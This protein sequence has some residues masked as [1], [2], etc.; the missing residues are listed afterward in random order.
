MTGNATFPPA[1]PTLSGDTLSINRFLKDPLW[2]MRVLRTI[3]EQMFV[4]DKILTG[5]LWT[6]S[7]SIG[8]EQTENIYADNAPQAVSPGAPYPRTT[9]GRGPASMANTVKWAQESTITDEDISRLNYDAIKR[10]FTKLA[11]SHVKAVDSVALSVIASAVTQTTAAIA[12]WTTSGSAQIMRDVM[13][14]YANIV[15]LLQGYQPDTVFCDVLTFANAVSD[16]T[17]LSQLPREVPGIGNAPVAAGWDSKYMRQIGGFTWICSPNLPTSSGTVYVLDSKVFGSFVD[18]RVPGPG[19][20]QSDDPGAQRIQCKTV[21]NDK[22][23]SWDVMCRRITVPIVV[24]PH[25]CWAIT[26][27]GA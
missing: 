12:P 24:E 19:W 15:D 16:P 6:E 20:V 5:Q 17:L 14:A 25:A 10:K 3:S 9:T 2:V 8:Y 4:S 27:V 1:P 11:N 23:D 18:E 26:G 7:G 13:L 22:T 21:R